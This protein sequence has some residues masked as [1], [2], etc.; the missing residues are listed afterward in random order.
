MWVVVGRQLEAALHLDV[1]P[2]HLGRVRADQA[3]LLNRPV[4]S[5]S[6]SIRPVIG[7]RV[8]SP[9]RTSGRV[10]QLPVVELD[11]AGCAADNSRIADAAVST[12]S[13]SWMAVSSGLHEE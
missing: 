8:P 6:S 12:P 7:R 2:P 9:G 1:V 4:S 3:D 5:P 10:E 11:A 13:A